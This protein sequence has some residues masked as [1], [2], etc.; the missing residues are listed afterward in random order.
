MLKAAAFP[1]TV[2]LAVLEHAERVDGTG[3]PRKL[4]GD[5]ISLYG[6]IIA[7]ATAYNGA[8]SR[9]PYKQERD[10]HSGIMDLLKDIGKHFDERILRAL[11]YTLSIYPI[12]TY[13]EL[14]NGAKGVVVRTN[15]NDPK[16]P[17][18]KLLLNEK[19]NLYAE[20]PVL[21]TKEGDSVQI[22]RSLSPEM[23]RELEERLG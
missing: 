22:A 23:V 15:I 7:V 20:T 16:Y 6:K 8:V 13:V 5:K 2:A 3:Y 10:G 14:T 9:R 18:I 12:G 21:Q 4:T 11:V 19:G 1:A 17:A